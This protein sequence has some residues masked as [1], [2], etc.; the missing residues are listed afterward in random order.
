MLS[1]RMVG[2]PGSRLRAKPASSHA[3]CTSR[4]TRS[5]AVFSTATVDL[6]MAPPLLPPVL[7]HLPSEQVS[8]HVSRRRQAAFARK[9]CD[10][11]APRRKACD[12]LAARQRTV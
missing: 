10:F 2:T 5:G 11:E 3:C 9:T 8:F 7:P 4:S 1:L 6:L 12:A